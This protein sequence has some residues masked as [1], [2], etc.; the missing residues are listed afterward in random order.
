[1]FKKARRDLAF[2]YGRQL[3]QLNYWLVAR[4]AMLIIGVL[5]LL[6]AD[7]ALNF[8]DRVARRIGPW[9]GRHDVAIDNL[10]KA[11]PEKS[12]SEIQAIASDMWVI[13]W[14]P[15][16][17]DVSAAQLSVLPTPSEVTTPMP[18]TATI[19]LPM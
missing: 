6:P 15:D 5:R 12:D 10:R 1:M 19:G 3:R 13:G 11:Y 17:P 8:A 16:L 4:A 7:S 2:R 14:M 9:V 18:V